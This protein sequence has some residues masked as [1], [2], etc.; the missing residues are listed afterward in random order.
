MK[1]SLTIFLTLILLLTACS[2]N[3]T[4][5]PLN[6]LSGNYSLDDAK[7]DNC[8]VFE[9]G[10]ITYGQSAW[11]S[12]IENTE[13]GQPET[14][15]LGFYYTLGDPSH[16]SEEYYEE[17]KDDYPILYINDL[18]FNGK[19]YIIE[20]IEEGQLISKEYKYLVK[21]EGQPRP[22]AL[23]SEYTY[24]V[25]VNDNTVTWDDIEHGMLSSK[26]GDYIDHYLVYSDLEMY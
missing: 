9:D 19:K 22:S 7:S 6:Q 16:Y 12:F 10:D 26:F 17:I 23:Y 15:R 11:D 1:K 2:Q 13:N 20:S 5:A 8:V 18:S 24:Y 4:R 14:A 3:V 21:Y 25:L